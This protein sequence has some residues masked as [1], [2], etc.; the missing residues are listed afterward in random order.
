MT[1]NVCADPECF[2]RGGGTRGGGFNSDV[3]FLVDEGRTEDPYITLKA[4]H[5]RSQAKR[6]LNG[7]SLAGR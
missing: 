1:S 4:G 7:V 2:V 5:H 3:F 6:H